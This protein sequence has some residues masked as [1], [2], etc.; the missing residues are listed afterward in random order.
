M[1][2]GRIPPSWKWFA[3]LALAWLACKHPPGEAPGAFPAGV[4]RPRLATP[5]DWS[6]PPETTARVAGALSVRCVI[7][8][9]GRAEECQVSRSIPE[10][11][12]WVI[13]K[14]E[15]A[16]FVA[17]TYRGTPVRSS[18]LFN[19]RFDV[20][21]PPSRWRPPVD[22]SQIAACKGTSAQGCMAAALGL[23]YPD[24]GSR[25]VDRA[26][27]LLG[28]ACAAGLAAACRQLDESFLAPRL[29]D[30]VSPP[31][32]LE[33]RGAEG[34]V[35]CWISATGHARDCRG[36][37]SAPA[38]WFIETLTRARFAPAKFEGEPFETEYVVG[39][40]FK[41]Y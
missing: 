2:A 18:Y 27:R 29:L 13:S 41:R 15:G 5:I 3:A 8:E 19:I 20:P 30:D 36:P 17:A 10:L 33:F 12:P 35:V 22:A 4:T 39:F 11:D 25:E 9:E 32:N 40:Y 23:L 14:L 31:S 34:E 1:Q 38:A 21:E 24:G 7:T 16:S 28:A 37:G 6:Y 26:S